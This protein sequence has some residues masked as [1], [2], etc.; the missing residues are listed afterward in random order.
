MVK[1]IKEKYINQVKNFTKYLLSKNKSRKGT[2]R[3]I[4]FMSCE[5]LDDG[6]S[7]E[8]NLFQ[9]YGFSKEVI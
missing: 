7:L 9:E 5:L 4:I 6:N 8:N 3:E 1:Q 2:E